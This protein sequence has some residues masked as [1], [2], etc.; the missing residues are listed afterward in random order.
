MISKDI[1][2]TDLQD[3]YNQLYKLQ[4]DAH[5]PEYML[6]HDEIRKCLKDSFANSYT[7]FGVNQ[8][9]TLA[10]AFFEKTPHIT[11][12]DL[13]LDRYRKAQH[14][15]EQYAISNQ[16]D[17]EIH[18]ANTLKVEIAPCDVLYIDTA[19]VY[20]HLSKELALHGNK[21]QKYIVFHDTF[22]NPG[23]KKAIREFIA[24]NPQWSIVTECDIN[25]GFMTIKRTI[26][27]V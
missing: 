2:A 6:V 9:T 24:K 8:G 21:A 18:E 25:V 15:F 26:K 19:H 7:E 16:L 5:K 14:H 4:S 17:F 13:N 10:L 3:Y 22:T 1:D 27:H 11:A 20:D 23:L 12:Y